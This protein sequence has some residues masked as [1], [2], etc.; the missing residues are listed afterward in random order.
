MISDKI[1][2]LT[3]YCGYRDYEVAKMIGLEQANY[4]R[5]IRSNAWKAQ[6][7]IDIA[8]ALGWRV[9]FVKDDNKIYIDD[10]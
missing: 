3:N 8:H 5:K 9:A 6:D 1:K 7:L 10:K 2:A 4:S